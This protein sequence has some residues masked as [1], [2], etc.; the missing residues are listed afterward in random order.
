MKK[1][2]KDKR[3][4]SLVLVLITMTF[5]IM[6]AGAIIT[7][8]I[9][10]IWLKASQKKSQEN[11]YVTDSVLDS[12]AAG[13]QNDSSKAS[14]EAYADALTGYMASLT[15][16]NDSLA[17]KYAGD[18]LSTMIHVLSGGA[19]AYSDGTTDYQF[20]DAVL[21]SYLTAEELP[22]YI[23]DTSAANEM[24]LRNESLILKNISVYKKDGTYETTLTT[25]ICVEVPMVTTDAHSEYLDYAILADNQI[26]ANAK[27]AV[28]N[29]NIYAGTVNRDDK[30]NS[31]KAGI[32]SREG[33]RIT[34]GGKLEVNAQ[35]IISRGDLALADGSQV[36]VKGNGSQT[37]KLWLENITL[38]AAPDG[39]AGG[40]KLFVNG[41]CNIADDMELNGKND[42]AKISGKYYGYNYNDNYSVTRQ[43]AVDASHSS[44][45]S[46]NGAEN[47]LDF[48]GLETLILS[49]RTFIA[50]K[51]GS[52]EEDNTIASAGAI[53]TDIELG[54]SLS[55]KSSQ[56]AYFVPSDYIK[57]LSEL[58][59]GNYTL[60][61]SLPGEGRVKI[62]GKPET[63]WLFFQVTTASGNTT[64][65]FDYQSYNSYVM[66][67]D[68]A[69]QT[70]LQ[71]TGDYS[72]IANQNHFDIRDYIGAGERSGSSI[73]YTYHNQ[74]LLKVYYRHNKLVS[75]Q[76]VK[77]FYLN[78]DTTNGVGKSTSRRASIFYAVFH[79]SSPEQTGVYNEVDDRYLSGN[80]VILSAA[81]DALMHSSGDI[82]YGNPGT[83]TQVKIQ[84]NDPL[85]EDSLL[86]YA[87]RKSK[88]YM[89]RQLALLGD[90][91]ESNISPLWRLTETSNNDL[92]KSGINSGK[93]VSNLFN[94][95]VDVSKLPAQA[96][97]FGTIGGNKVAFITSTGD[98]TWPLAA[99][100]HDVRHG[101]IITS[102]DVTLNSDFN[103]LIIAGGDVVIG[104]TNITVNADKEM[105]EDALALDKADVDPM[106]YN[107][108][109]KYFRK[110]VDATIGTTASKDLD[111]VSFENWKK[112]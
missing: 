93:K 11:F 95:L 34:H 97:K 105:V 51:T 44:A 75:Q 42:S 63:D 23:G 57:T 26:L 24:E 12:V 43:T 39:K 18:Y 45:I 98:V 53:N 85:A 25:D 40:N 67:D 50:K 27:N 1:L 94:K 62:A 83:G 73:T 9:T 89:S 92:S 7:M 72:M 108:L 5:I 33:I 60:P 79:D 13:I 110:S 88:E 91:S 65:A 69:Y 99:P 41:E 29:G 19:C 52:Q 16:A 31:T 6:L 86:S 74:S 68:T 15:A 100:N 84:N 101:I 103:G 48:S 14:A 81:A 109:S 64:Y 21:K 106:I 59:S 80:G 61:P 104:S 96:T 82:L 32:R 112:N 46:L 70:A 55:V 2:L 76:P 10:N 58:G 38:D 17:E 78:F 107:L 56:L 77:Y 30:D 87:Q 4:S 22:Y 71:K 54:A 37:A 3:G 66:P 47:S 35:Y 111:N 49:G 20:S 90:Y 102:G 28:I 36:D 8:T